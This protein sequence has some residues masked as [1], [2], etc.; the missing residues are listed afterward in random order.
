MGIMPEDRQR[1]WDEIIR[2]YG[3]SR[4]DTSKPETTEE[5]P[6]P[7]PL[8]AVLPPEVASAFRKKL[9]GKS[10]PERG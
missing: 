7:D 10:K 5:T 2:R 4:G 1:R 8:H 6:L 9:N 3:I